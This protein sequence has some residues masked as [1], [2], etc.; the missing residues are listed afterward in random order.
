M[1]QSQSGLKSVQAPITF[2][3]ATKFGFAGLNPHM[4]RHGQASILVDN[5]PGDW[6]TV[7]ARLGNLGDTCQKFYAWI[8]AEELILQGQRLLFEMRSVI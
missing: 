4:V 1:K 7:F 5:T 6:Q 8:R 3:C 2:I